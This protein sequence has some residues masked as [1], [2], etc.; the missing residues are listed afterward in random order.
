VDLGV[1]EPLEALEALEAPEVPEDLRPKALI[2]W[3]WSLRQ[4]TYD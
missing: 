3:Q 1:L 2:H 4:L